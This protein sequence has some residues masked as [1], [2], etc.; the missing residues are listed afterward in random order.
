MSRCTRQTF[1]CVERQ[2]VGGRVIGQD[3]GVGARQGGERLAQ[4]SHAA[5]ATVA[6]I[7]GVDHHDVEVACQSAMLKAIVQQV[8]PRAEILFREP[9]GG[10]TVFPDHYRYFEAAR[11][12]A[13]A[14]R[15]IQRH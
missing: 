10:I 11:D 2:P 7:G 8:Q 15:R 4:S 3:D 6:C 5:A 9:A 12:Q 14:R 1:W 13:A